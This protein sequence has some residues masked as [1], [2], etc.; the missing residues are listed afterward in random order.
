METFVTAIVTGIIL[1]IIIACKKPELEAEKKRIKEQ[2]E[3]KKAHPT[4]KRKYDDNPYI[5]YDAKGIPQV[6]MKKISGEEKKNSSG[7][8]D[9]VKGAVVG[10]IVAGPAGAVVGAIVGKD[11]ADKK[12]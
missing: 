2:E 7:T 1:L 11:K 6:D 3:Y 5:Y 9:I 12:R 4:V 8:K 10:G